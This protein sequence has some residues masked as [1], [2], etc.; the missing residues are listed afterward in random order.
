MEQ[1][2]EAALQEAHVRLLAAHS[3]AMATVQAELHR[4]RCENTQLRMRLAEA[5]LQPEQWL[6]YTRMDKQP[7]RGNTDTADAS[8]ARR[9]CGAARPMGQ[10]TP[11]AVL[12]GHCSAPSQMNPVAEPAASVV[13]AAA[14]ATSP[15]AAS[16]SG[17][18]LPLQQTWAAQPASVVATLEADSAAG[19]HEGTLVGAARDPEP[20]ASPRA[21]TA[22]QEASGA[23]TKPMPPAGHA[24]PLGQAV[25]SASTLTL[26]GASTTGMAADA[27]ASI[28][29][30][31]DQAVLAAALKATL[32]KHGLHDVKAR[33]DASSGSW[34]VAG[35]TLQLRLQDVDASLAGEQRQVGTACSVH[36]RVLMCT[37]DGRNWEPLEALVARHALRHGVA[38]APPQP[39]PLAAFHEEGDAA[40]PG[41]LASACRVADLARRPPEVRALPV[42]SPEY[43]AQQAPMVSSA[44]RT[45]MTGQGAASP[46]ASPPRPQQDNELPA[47]RADGLPAFNN[48]FPTSFSALSGPSHYYSQFRVRVPSSSQYEQREQ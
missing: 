14:S 47:W 10:G 12:H 16:M 38:A 1:P 33:C 8:D 44:R 9:A 37:C 5:G 26:E 45:R 6:S 35:V 22:V 3:A 15:G 31:A 19:L 7:V 32:R 41:G 4:M 25:A 43:V 24:T 36:H 17:N 2:F 29:G 21:T 23:L 20:C 18:P 48:A 46:P 39:L 40:G 34:T 30:K 27:A 28:T 13:V 11:A 42:S